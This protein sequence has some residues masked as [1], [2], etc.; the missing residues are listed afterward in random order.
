MS[1]KIFT[2][3]D[4][5][6]EELEMLRAIFKGAEAVIDSMADSTWLSNTLFD[7]KEK[8]GIYDLLR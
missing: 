1:D 8:L 7:I 3:E 2:E 5:T 6:E 4:F